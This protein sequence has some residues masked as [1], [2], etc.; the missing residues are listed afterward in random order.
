MS[1]PSSVAQPFIFGGLLSDALRDS[2][3]LDSEALQGMVGSNVG[4][5]AF[6]H[7]IRHQ[8]LGFGDPVS[9][10]WRSTPGD[11]HAA[12]SIGIIPCA[13][14]F[15]RHQDL[16]DVAGLLERLDV[17]LV[18][19][20][21]GA[22]SHVDYR[23]PQ[24]PS[25]TVRWLRAIADRAGSRAS[26]IAVRGRFTRRAL[27]EYGFR[28]VQVVGCPSLF[29]NPSHSLGQRIAERAARPIRRV[30]AVAGHPEWRHLARIER[31]LVRLVT[32]THGAYVCQGPLPMMRLG[33]GEVDR[34]AEDDVAR[35]LWYLSGDDAQAPEPSAGEREG[36]S[37]SKK[38]P[39][40]ERLS[41]GEPEGRGPSKKE[42]ETW[43]LNHAIA[44][45]HV[46]AWLEYLRRFDFVIGTRIHG[47]ALGL[48]AGVPAICVAFDSRTREL[49]ET[50]AVPHI[51][52]RDYADL[53]LADL[54]GA[55]AARFDAAGFDRNRRALARSYCEFLAGN[56]LRVADHVRE[57]ATDSHATNAKGA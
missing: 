20:G 34:L 41:A 51:L 17:P 11:I 53:S 16:G 43:A 38:E 44:F 24:V 13:N 33:R 52:A 42:L 1:S 28:N 27:R 26:N 10:P 35:C 32:Q 49:C 4:N 14:N 46:P 18:A 6:F 19:I 50:M 48:Q 8:I 54:P 31:S 56:G 40:E 2:P 37:P 3:F 30:A 55:F 15:G 36:R 45:V 57:I 22:Q 39:L 29:L 5:L 23:L 12:G 47:V 9:V 21:L 25:G 7:A